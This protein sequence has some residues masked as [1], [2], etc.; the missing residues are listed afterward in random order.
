M[1]LSFRLIIGRDGSAAAMSRGTHLTRPS[2]PTHQ[3]RSLFAGQTISY[4]TWNAVDTAEAFSLI[5]AFG[6]FEAR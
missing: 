3:R 1:P 4:L 2:R 5:K 6:R